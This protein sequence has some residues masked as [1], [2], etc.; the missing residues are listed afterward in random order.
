MSV[1]LKTE[2]IRLENYAMKMR[3][4]PS[5]AQKEQLDKMFWA[6]RLAYNMTFHEVFQQHPAVCG[7]PDENGN[8]WPSY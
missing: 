6:L 2:K 8:V 3:L 4:Y 7:A 5:P 1:V